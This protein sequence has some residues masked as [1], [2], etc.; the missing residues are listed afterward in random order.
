MLLS[1]IKS[2]EDKVNI[3]LDLVNLNGFGNK[4]ISSLSCS[5]RQRVAIARGII[6][7]FIARI[8]F[9][10]IVKTYHNHYDILFLEL[11]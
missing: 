1:N 6:Q 10:N 9:A 8:H 11:K 4:I 5:E 2:K 7:Y 3:I